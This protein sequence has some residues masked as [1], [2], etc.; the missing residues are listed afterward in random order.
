MKYNMLFLWYRNDTNAFKKGGVSM[1]VEKD[2]L[3]RN[4][5]IVPFCKF[6]GNTGRYVETSWSGGGDSQNWGK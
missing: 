5:P 2:E 3:L 6:D 1:Y 4:D